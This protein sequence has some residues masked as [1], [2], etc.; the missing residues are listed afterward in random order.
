MTKDKTDEIGYLEDLINEFVAEKDR[1][2]E[3]YFDENNPNSLIYHH[4]RDWYKS[5]S[6]IIFEIKTALRHNK[7]RNQDGVE[8]CLLRIYSDDER[9]LLKDQEDRVKRLVQ[10]YIDY[11]RWMDKRMMEILEDV[12]EMK[13]GVIK[14]IGIMSTNAAFLVHYFLSKARGDVDVKVPESEIYKNVNITLSGPRR[15]KLRNK[16]NATGMITVS[17][18]N[19]HYYWQ[20]TPRG[21]N[22]LTRVFNALFKELLPDEG[23]RK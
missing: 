14:L 21:S 12:M 3:L 8:D 18:D 17:K 23:G 19:G 15:E 6:A 16:L 5:R 1:R 9:C 2:K 7:E 22:T 11:L 10:L 13:V 4:V 20:L